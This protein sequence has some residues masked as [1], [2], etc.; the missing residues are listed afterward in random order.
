M[1]RV[2]SNKQKDSISAQT[3]NKFSISIVLNNNII[4]MILYYSMQ[5]TV[6]NISHSCRKM[7]VATI[8]RRQRGMMYAEGA[9]D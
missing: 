8:K 1:R 6:S 4:S 3:M 2:R 7:T 5:K 9:K